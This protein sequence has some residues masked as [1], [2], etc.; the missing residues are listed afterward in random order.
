M[1]F[2]IGLLLT[3]LALGI[4][5]I[6]LLLQEED[7]LPGG[8]DEFEQNCSDLRRIEQEEE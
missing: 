8:L 7:D 6:G 5:A 1:W 3:L 4:G 2:G